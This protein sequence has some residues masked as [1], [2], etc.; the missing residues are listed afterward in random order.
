MKPFL[1]PSDDEHV[2]EEEDIH[3]L[4]FPEIQEHE[5]PFQEDLPTGAD[6]QAFARLLVQRRL[7][8]PQETPP[9]FVSSVL[10]ALI[11]NGEH[12]A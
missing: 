3:L 5:R 8:H 4:R 11:T 9:L 12:N 6:D 10:C 2:I 1:A 7:F